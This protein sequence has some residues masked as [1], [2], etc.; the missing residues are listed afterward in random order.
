MLSRVVSKPSTSWI[1]RKS[2][3]ISGSLARPQSATRNRTATNEHAGDLPG[4]GVLGGPVQ[5]VKQKAREHDLE[6]AIGI[7][8]LGRETASKLKLDAGCVAFRRVVTIRGSAS[9]P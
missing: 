5:V 4:G 8:E 7:G 1:V 6:R 2:P 9:R 3:R